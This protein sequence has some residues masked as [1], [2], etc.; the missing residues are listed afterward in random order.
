MPS[1]LQQGIYLFFLKYQC[2]AIFTHLFVR[3]M[4]I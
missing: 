1:F 2:I 4:F 3:D